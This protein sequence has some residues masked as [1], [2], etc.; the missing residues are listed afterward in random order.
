MDLGLRRK[1]GIQFPASYQLAPFLAG[2]QRADKP[3]AL[4]PAQRPWA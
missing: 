3:I 2:M 1:L 4:S